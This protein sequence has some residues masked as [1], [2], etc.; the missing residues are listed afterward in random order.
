MSLVAGTN[1]NATTLYDVAV[2]WVEQTRYLS[3]KTKGN[4]ESAPS[5]RATGISVTTANVLHVDISVLNPPNGLNPLNSALGQGL[6]IPGI[7]SGW[8]VYVGAQGGTLF[9][10]NA[11]PIA[12]GTTG[13]T[14]A[15]APVLSG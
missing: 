6:V 1:A 15:G 5:A 11:T 4:S 2:T 8:N 12:I 10:Q 9:L 14:L 3:P 7:A 13:Y